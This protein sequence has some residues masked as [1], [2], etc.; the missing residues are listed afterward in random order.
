MAHGKLPTWISS[1]D[2]NL[3]LMVQVQWFKYKH[4]HCA[5]HVAGKRHILLLLPSVQIAINSVCIHPVKHLSRN[6]MLCQ[7]VI[8]A[9]TSPLRHVKPDIDAVPLLQEVEERP[10]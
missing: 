1:N 8:P 3:P 10:Q 6:S 4:L 9:T 7:P 5:C 2:C